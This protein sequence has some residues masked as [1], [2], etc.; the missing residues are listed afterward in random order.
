AVLRPV[1]KQRA[2]QR[3]NKRQDDRNR[4]SEQGRLQGVLRTCFFA[5]GGQPQAPFAPWSQLGFLDGDS[6]SGASAANPKFAPYC[7][8]FRCELRVQ[9]GTKIIELLVSFDSEVRIERAASAGRTSESG[10]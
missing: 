10:H 7:R 4:C 9:S 3:C 2:D 5:G 1:D 8:T 6:V